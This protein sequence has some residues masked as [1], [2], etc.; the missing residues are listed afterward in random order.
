[1]PRGH[2]A[3]AMPYRETGTARN[4]A[5]DPVTG[6]VGPMDPF[7]AVGHA[8]PSVGKTCLP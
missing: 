7:S 2:P 3:P 5:N 4:E 1:L 6:P 8:E